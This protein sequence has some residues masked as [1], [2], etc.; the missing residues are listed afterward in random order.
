VFVVIFNQHDGSFLR[1]QLLAR[2][3]IAQAQAN[4][5]QCGNARS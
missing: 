3:V 5:Q 2:T 1:G 4:Y